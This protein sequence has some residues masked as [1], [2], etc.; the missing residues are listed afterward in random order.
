MRCS[1]HP[2]QLLRTRM[3]TG[4]VGAPYRGRN[5]FCICE[6]H[7]PPQIAMLQMAMPPH[8]AISKWP[9]LRTSPYSRI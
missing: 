5:S 6:E 3:I 1:K 4:R 8:I 9:C 7:M 2:T